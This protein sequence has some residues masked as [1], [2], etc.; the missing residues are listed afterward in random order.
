[1]TQP[2]EVLSCDS[3]HSFCHSLRLR[4]FETGEFTHWRTLL[5]FAAGAARTTWGGRTAQEAEFAETCKARRI[6][7]H[8]VAESCS[9]AFALQP[10]G[11]PA[12]YP[13]IKQQRSEKLFK[14]LLAPVAAP[15]QS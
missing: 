12:A 3:A 4:S 6:V 7:A 15:R 9:A 2:T 10:F 5:P 13:K 14:T 11:D 8:S 1:M